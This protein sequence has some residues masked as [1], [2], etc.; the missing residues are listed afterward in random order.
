LHYAALH[1]AVAHVEGRAEA[2]VHVRQ[3]AAQS[4][5]GGASGSSE[6]LAGAQL[7]AVATE[8]FQHLARDVRAWVLSGRAVS[9]SPSA[10]SSPTRVPTA[11]GGPGRAKHAM[12]RSSGRVS[13]RDHPEASASF[14]VD[15]SRW[16]AFADAVANESQHHDALDVEMTGPWPPYDFVRLQFGG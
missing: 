4:D 9:S 2:R 7:D 15:R 1:E 8:I 5:N 10:A 13:D 16:R 12:S 11:V 3:A 6:S 14:L